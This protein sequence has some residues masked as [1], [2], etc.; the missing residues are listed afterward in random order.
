MS[1]EIDIPHGWNPRDYQTRLFNNFGHGLQYDR[2]SVIWHRR[3]G[4]DSTGLNLT[5]REMFKRKGTYWH[6]F[7]EQAQARKATWNGIDGSGRR[8]IDQFLPPA[9]RTR[10]KEDE[11]LIEVQ[12]GATWQMAGSDRYDSLVGSN[13]VGVVFTEYAL[14]NPEAWDYI[15][16]ILIENGGW[17]LFITTPRGRNHAYTQYRNA[18]ALP[19]WYSERLTIDDTK[20]FITAEDIQAER[21]SGMSE[22]KI[23]QEYYCSFDAETDDQMI[24][25][26]TVKRAE[27][28]GKPY[29]DTNDPRILGVD[30]ARFG[31]DSSVL[32][33]RVGN[34]AVSIP[35]E[36]FQGLNTMQLAAKVCAAIDEHHIDMTFIDGGAM[37]PGVIDR[38]RQLGYDCIEVNFGSTSD[39]HIEGTPKAADKRSEMWINLR[40]ALERGL[41]IPQDELLNMELTAPLYDYDTNNA[42]RLES[43]KAMKKRKVPS[44]DVA[45][46]LALT[47][48][49]ATKARAIRQA[50]EQ[51]QDDDYD[52]IW[53]SWDR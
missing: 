8:I 21:E 28:R 10:K 11:M 12:G 3:A 2:A 40:D 6:L 25:G 7:P 22:A 43:K 31:D 30:V 19:N 51:R 18:L 32:A 49:Y 36:R 29:T 20:N 15:R 39:R 24:P 26:R 33:F 9:V 34:D 14:S 4:K 1:V 53:Q 48:A 35:Y 42:V 44:P 41:S 47:Y 46:A 16:P 17:A 50:E 5:A 23:Q 13:P 45:D 37:G 52:P 27:A 38:V